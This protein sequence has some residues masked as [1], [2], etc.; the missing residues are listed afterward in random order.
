MLEY[1]SAYEKEEILFNTKDSISIL[2]NVKGQISNI[3]TLKNKLD[4]YELNI[5]NKSMLISIFGSML[6]GGFTTYFTNLNFLKTLIQAHS[7]SDIILNVSLGSFL[8]MIPLAIPI[9]LALTFFEKK[10]FSFFKGRNRF[11]KEI[12]DREQSFLDI[13]KEPE[14]KRVIIS[15]LQ[16]I[17]QLMKSE[18]N[19]V[20][21]ENHFALLIKSLKNNDDEH[22]KNDLLKN[23]HYWEKMRKNVL[24]DRKDKESH[25]TFLK[26]IGVTPANVIEENNISMQPDIK[27]ML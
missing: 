22:F 17:A 26:S 12:Y 18:A 25:N 23:F 2:D 15:E 27:S 3:K 10:Y 20:N 16:D 11:K 13:I 21:F 6:V 14:V 9:G 5:M 7:L 8:I 19:N 1:E 4:E 24:E